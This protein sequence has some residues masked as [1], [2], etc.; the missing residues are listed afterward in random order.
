MAQYTGTDG[1]IFTEIDE[2]FIKEIAE[3]LKD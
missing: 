3:I 1:A 2:Q